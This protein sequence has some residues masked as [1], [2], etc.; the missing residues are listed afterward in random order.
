MSDRELITSNLDKCWSS[1]VNFF[2][3]LTETHWQV[4]SLCSECSIK[5]VASHLFS[6]EQALSDWIRTGIKVKRHFE[7]LTG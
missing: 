7:L 3:S 5:D 1:A 4:Q 6:V 2:E